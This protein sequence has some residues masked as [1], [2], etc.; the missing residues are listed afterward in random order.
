MPIKSQISP[1]SFGHQTIRLFVE[2]SGNTLL[3]LIY[4]CVG[5]DD[6]AHVEY[7]SLT[8]P[9]DSD[10]YL[11]HCLTWCAFSFLCICPNG[12]VFLKQICNLG[13]ILS[14]QH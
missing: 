3:I 2:R 5:L 13:F 10:K 1:A 4:T 11:R 14:Y 7:I 8:C 12:R 9:G 6:D